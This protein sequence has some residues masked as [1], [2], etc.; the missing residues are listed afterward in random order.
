V[1]FHAD[2]VDAVTSA[3]IPEGAPVGVAGEA[4]PVQ[5]VRKHLFDER[6]ITRQRATVRGYWKRGAAGSE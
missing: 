6:G 4:A 2:V 5:R 3:D 1:S